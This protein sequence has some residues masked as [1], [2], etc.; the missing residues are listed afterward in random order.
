M[1]DNNLSCREVASKFDIGSHAAVL[2]WY[3]AYTEEGVHGLMAM[4]NI[5]RP[6]NPVSAS[7]T[8]SKA[9]PG[10]ELEALRK[11]NER[12]KTEN[13]YLKKLNALVREKAG[14]KPPTR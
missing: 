5:G 7:M 11:E 9:P 10:D 12:L 4:K 6:S 1:I 13:A 14:S 2:R 3:K 8:R